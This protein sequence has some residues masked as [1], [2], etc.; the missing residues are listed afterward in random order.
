M[1]EALKINN[2]LV[3]RTCRYKTFRK[4][5]NCKVIVTWKKKGDEDISILLLED[6]IIDV[7]DEDTNETIFKGKA[8]D[9]FPGWTYSELKILFEAFSVGYERGYNEGSGNVDGSQP[10]WGGSG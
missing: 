1:K 9:F 2:L 10:S 8:E 5:K 7:I 3:T 6:E 4:Y